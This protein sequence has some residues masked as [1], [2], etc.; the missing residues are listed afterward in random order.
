MQILKIE[1]P[2]GFEVDSFD[3]Q[4]GEIK[5]K[6][7]PKDVLERILTDDDVFT[8][9][10]I[11]RAI[12]DKRCEGLEED[13]KATRFLK[14]LDKSLNGCDWIPDFDN[15]SQRKFIPWFEGGSSGFR[16]LVYVHWSSNSSVGSRLCFKESR[17][18]VHA[19]TKFTKWYKQAIVVNQSSTKTPN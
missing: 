11:T 12:F 18:A 19:G 10:G 17:L 5:F 14:L 7:K 13:E 6:E 9:N 3:K 1:I 2:Q 4:S 8:D 15:P 16:F